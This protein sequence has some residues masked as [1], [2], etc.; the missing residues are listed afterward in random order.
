M[1]LSIYTFVKD[2]LYGDFH[3][4]EMLKHHLPLAD[5]IVVNEGFSSDGTYEAIKDLDPRVKVVR[6]QLD[7]SEP[8]AWLRKS[9]DQARRLCT[10]DWCI[11]VDCDEF[12]PEWEFG[13]LREYLARTDKHLV[14][15]TYKH[16]YG[17]YKV[18]Y[19][20]DRPFPPK[21]K[22]IIHRNRPDVEIY[23]DG[24][25]VR[26]SSLGGAAEET[27]ETFECHHFGEVRR[28]ARLRHKWH[29][30]AKRDIRNRWSW[31]PAFVFDLRP[32]NWFDEDFLKDLKIYDGP[33]VEAVRNNPDEFVRDGF[34]L[35]D[36]LARSG[37]ETSPD[38][39][40]HPAPASGR[41]SPLT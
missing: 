15:A 4:V 22:Q 34:A 28:A 33:F 19:D 10:G 38:L 5:E 30:Q 9:K 36:A 14:S 20:S 37:P 39:S 18:V 2:G 11:L 17:N 7:R 26:I 1:K 6:N 3:V 41:R 8:E 16:F 24:S 29:V 40:G 25:D 27:S 12:I 23:G 31:L 35:Y 21:R 13:R 32:H